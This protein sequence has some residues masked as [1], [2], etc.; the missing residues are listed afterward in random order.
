MCGCAAELPACLV[1]AS[2]WTGRGGPVGFLPAD[3][4]GK[5]MRAP[6]ERGLPHTDWL[7]SRILMSSQQDPDSVRGWSRLCKRMA[8]SVNSGS[9]PAAEW[10]WT[11]LSFCVHKMGLIFTQ[12]WHHCHGVCGEGKMRK[13][14]AE[15]FAYG[16]CSVSED[17]SNTY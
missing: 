1:G 12:A 7:C 5:G 17:S 8:P 10:P 9:A 16:K 3:H 13:T 4:M 6:G 14:Q 11:R 2:M 15:C